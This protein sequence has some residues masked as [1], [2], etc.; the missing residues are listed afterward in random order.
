[1]EKLINRLVKDLGVTEAQARGGAGLL[2]K[3]AREKLAA[4]DFS[5]LA[6][7]L[8]GIEDLVSEIPTA[9]AS[10]GDELGKLFSLLRTEPG[11]PSRVVAGF[12]KLGLESNMPGKFTR[13]I[14][15]FVESEGGKEV[16]ALLEEAYQ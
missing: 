2:F 14:L 8:P 1:M 9:R 10:R 15:A 3:Q 12:L 13:V 11:A 5:R 7:V 6:A 16:R 4:A